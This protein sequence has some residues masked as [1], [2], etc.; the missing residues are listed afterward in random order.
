VALSAA[1]AALQV[2]ALG[3][4]HVG[5]TSLRGE[6]LLSRGAAIALALVVIGLVA[7]APTT[8]VVRGL[9]LGAHT[10]MCLTSVAAVALAPDPLV[11]GIA[12]SM[13]MWVPH[14]M[15][16]WPARFA[17]AFYTVPAVAYLLGVTARQTSPEMSV[18][19]G[20]TLYLFAVAAVCTVSSDLKYRFARREFTARTGL[21]RANAELEAS[22]AQLVCAQQ[23]L[24]ASEKRAE[25]IELVQGVAHRLN[26]PLGAVRASA[27]GLE[28]S[29]RPAL[30][31]LAARLSELDGARRTSLLALLDQALTAPVAALTAREERAERRRVQGVLSEAGVT[32]PAPLARGIV[33]I[34]LSDQVLAHLPLVRGPEAQADLSV[35]RELASLVRSAGY[36]RVAADQA[37]A[38]VRDLKRHL[39]P[40]RDAT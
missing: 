20:V 5:A 17:A 11:A 8:T 6:S 23:R 30:A 39:E 34:G 13:V 21:A 7:R 2:L 25:R 26:T 9:N 12:F 29:T 14:A 37:A 22:M 15:F 31:D 40:D 16:R 18:I 35:A 19:A 1:G 38:I 3:V 27:E 24:V 10:A 33:E 32:E 28:V 36:I 4:D